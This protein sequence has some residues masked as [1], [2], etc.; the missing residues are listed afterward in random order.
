MQ[1]V[2]TEIHPLEL[3]LQKPF[4]M[5]G[6]P[7]IVQVTAV[8]LHLVLRDGRSAWGCAVAHPDL[9]GE[10][11]RQVLQACQAGAAL[12]TDL[13][14]ANMEHS[15]SLLTPVLKDSPAAMCAF[16]LALYD[17]LGLLVGMPLHR[18][19]G[20]YRDR[21]QTSMTLPIGP[22]DETVALAR[23]YARAGFRLLKVKGGMDPAEDIE[24][25]RSVRRALPEHTLRLD[26]DGGYTPRQAVEVACALQAELE[27]LEQPIPVGDLEGLTELT[28][29]CSVPVIA[30][31]SV[32]G[33]DSVLALIPRRSVSGICIKLA[34]C[35]GLHCARQMETIARVARLNAMVSCVV[36]PALLAAAGLSL[37]LS[38]P[39][40]QYCDLDG[41]LHLAE[42]PSQQT[43]RMEDG[44]LIASEVPGLG[45]R[46]QLG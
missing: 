34:S 6:I 22:V 45:C 29:L 21:I 10:S 46:V 4:R 36:E 23:E 41:H 25:V 27:M 30:D 37:A 12:A 18:L 39:S 2:K 32:Q 26:A 33:P 42:D 7:P 11:P 8:F 28:R 40:V 3:P 15:L 17:L 13:N 14:P 1:I 19:L 31:Q 43:F 5:A 24:R 44:W 16:D 9:T 20:G 35:G 38:S